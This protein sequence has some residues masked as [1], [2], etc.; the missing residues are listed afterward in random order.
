LNQRHLGIVVCRELVTRKAQA[1]ND[2]TKTL[3]AVV[4]VFMVC[5]VLNPIRRIMM[6]LTPISELGCGSTYFYF[7]YMSTPIIVLDAS[8]HFFI[9]SLCNKRFV[10][11][12]SQK[13]RRLVYRATVSPAVEP[14][15][16]DPGVVDPQPTPQNIAKITPRSAVDG[17]ENP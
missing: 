3:V 16:D 12:L 7:A 11:K 1:E 13:W 10:E 2:M 4:L 15:A 9:Y 14:Q 8:S 5:Q 17:G 6:A